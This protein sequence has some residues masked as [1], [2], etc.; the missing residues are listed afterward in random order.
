MGVDPSNQEQAR[1][2]DGDEGA[3]WAAH[4]ANYDRALAG[5]HSILLEA[6][7]LGAADAVLDVGCGCGRTTRDAARIA[8]QGSALGVDLSA[9]MLDVAR[10]LAAEEGLGNVR[11]VQADAQVHRFESEGFDAVLSRFGALFFGDPVAAF[12]N[13]ARALRPGGR[14]ALLAWQDVEHNEWV[15]ALRAAVAVGRELPLP[16]AEG[17]GPFALSDPGRVR[18]IL[19]RAGF[20]GVELTARSA[21][22]DYGEDVD[23]ALPFL[24]RSLARA[25]K[26][27]DETQRAQAMDS[28][29]DTL[30]AHRTA[31]G[32]EFASAA[33]VITARRPA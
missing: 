30:E 25:F 21:T 14:L 19:T 32:V 12:T 29:R 26:D 8:T 22:L 2:W 9:A 1:N 16:P 17:P 13:L 6:A 18:D 24:S 15:R 4:A 7:S 31:I 33:W 23:T 3:F 5:Y 10:R 28:L 11:F 20:T 27:L